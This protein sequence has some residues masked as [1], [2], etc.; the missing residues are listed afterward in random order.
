MTTQ[1]AFQPRAQNQE[2]S[3]SPEH[4]GELRESSDVV[5]APELLRARMDEDGYV[6]LRGWLNREEVQDARM[7]CLR[8]LRDADQLHPD[9]PLEMGVASPVNRT[10]WVPELA[11]GNAPLMKVLYEGAMTDFYGRLFGEEVLH[12]TFTWLRAIGPGLATPPHCD[13]VYMGRGTQ[14]LY[15]SWTPL[16]D[17]TYEQG[18]LMMLENSHKV[19]KLNHYRS[20]DVDAVCSNRSDPRHNHTHEGG[21]L[22]EPPRMGA[23][24]RNGGWLTRTPAT[25]R[26]RLGGRWLTSEFQM[27][28]LL[29]F[30]VATVHG[31]LDNQSDRVRLSSDSRYQRASE[32]ADERWIGANPVGHGDAGKRALIC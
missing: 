5:N 15:T 9:F 11:R 20:K 25:L 16:G 24:M 22:Q 6:F 23:Q 32:P 17:V 4:W 19:E 2:L 7:E 1:T 21:W 27:G 18:G 28:D 14:Q 13:V 12:F 10:A 31:S 29:A 3:T 26:E 30:S 8:R